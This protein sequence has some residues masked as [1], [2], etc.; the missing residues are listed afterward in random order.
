MIE[1]DKRFEYKGI[2]NES[3]KNKIKE[4][5]DTEKEFTKRLQIK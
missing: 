2:E 1:L 4:L 5:G 3:I